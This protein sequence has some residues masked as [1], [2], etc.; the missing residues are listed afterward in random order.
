[1][2]FPVTDETYSRPHAG[3]CLGGCF[4][5]Q[6]SQDSCCDVLDVL[7]VF[8]LASNDRGFFWD[9][10]CLFIVSTAFMEPVIS[11]N[12]LQRLFQL[13][14]TSRVKLSASSNFSLSSLSAV[15]KTILSQIMLSFSWNSQTSAT[16]CNL[17]K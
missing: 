1:M 17:V 14:D 4:F 8:F 5:P 9:L 2:V 13:L 16:F 7:S 15:E 6:L 3:H 11:L 12:S 10:L